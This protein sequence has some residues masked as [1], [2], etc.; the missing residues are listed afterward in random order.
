V[1]YFI[2]SAPPTHIT[3]SAG[4]EESFPYQHALKYAQILKKSGI[5]LK[6]LPSKGSSENL[7][8][9]SDPSS[10]V[11]IGF[12]QGGV[13]DGKAENLVSLG[14]MSYQPLMIFYRGK[15][16]DLLSQLKGK[17]VVIG[18]IGS[19]VRSVALTVLSA[20]GI[21]ENENTEL[22][23]MSAEE[24]SKEL[25]NHRIDAV[26][27]MAESTPTPILRE[28]LRSK[29]VH[30][31]SFKQASAY[32]RKIHYLNVLEFP[33]GSID[34]GLNL[35][36]EDV[37]LVGPMI[38]LIAVKNL[39]PALSDL[40]LEAAT[41]VHSRPG[42]FQ[43]RGEFPNSLEHT[44]KVSDDAI[45]YYKSGKH[46]FY[47]YLPFWLA[48]ILSR[49]LFASIPTL[50][51]LI[52]AIRSLPAFFRWRVQLRIRRYY[53]ELLDLEQRYLLETDSAKQEQLRREFDQIEEKV[54]RS[55]IRAAFANQ[56]YGL[57]GHINYVR[58][59]VAKKSG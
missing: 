41:E 31:F 29:D 24:A 17:K 49:F 58:D 53:R 2:S 32:V 11:D 14:S 37:L 4:A 3:I 16:M 26:F 42:R 44:F 15:S 54:N 28:L 30:L 22:L 5:T 38:E 50:V 23:N 18:P 47:R 6:V 39:H 36:S 7:Q 55:K 45:R 19:G 25:L 33:Q 34:L 1:I 20:N 51:I 27:V 48:S 57:R 52:P 9:L 13:S 8:R 10:H 56:F 46:F 21:K 59:L 40:I 12:V 35:P 43:K